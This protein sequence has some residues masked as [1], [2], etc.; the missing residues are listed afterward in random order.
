MNNPFNHSKCSGSIL[1]KSTSLTQTDNNSYNRLTKLLIQSCTLPKSHNPIRKL[2][3]KVFFSFL[4]RNT[5]KRVWFEED[6]EEIYNY[7]ISESNKEED[8][9]LEEDN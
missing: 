6:E 7:D 9:D 3:I 8:L 2:E 5:M 1:T 4:S